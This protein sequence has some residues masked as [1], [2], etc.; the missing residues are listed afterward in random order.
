MTDT[1][2]MNR[3]KV[4]RNIIRIC[5]TVMFIQV[6][7]YLLIKNKFMFCCC[8]TGLPPALFFFFLL[9]VILCN[10]MFSFLDEPNIELLGVVWLS[11]FGI[12][13]SHGQEFFIRCVC[14]ILGMR[15]R[16]VYQC[17]C[18]CV[19]VCVCVCEDR[20]MYVCEKQ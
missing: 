12:C 2:K 4:I 1:S 3:I 11:G 7:F 17:A 15:V 18:V 14:F 6:S 16:A 8:C 5:L 19:C 9:E 20:G 13:S 10:L